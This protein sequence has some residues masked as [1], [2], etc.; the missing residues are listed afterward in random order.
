MNLIQRLATAFEI[1]LLV[2]LLGLY[3]CLPGGG[4][5]GPKPNLPVANNFLADS[6]NPVG[7][8]TPAQQD[9]VLVK[10]P[11]GP[12]PIEVLDAFNDMTYV[13]SGP[14]QFTQMSTSPYADGRRVLWGSGYDRIVKLDHD[15]QGIL[16]MYKL[17]DKTYRGFDQGERIISNLDSMSAADALNYAAS[18][19]ALLMQDL[20]GV[21]TLLDSNNEFYVSDSDNGQASITVYGDRNAGQLNSPI[22]VKRQFTLPITV[23]GSLVGVN[24]TYDGYLVLATTHGYVVVLARD[25]SDYAVIR[26]NYADTE[27]AETF[28]TP[29]YG[30]VRNSFAVDSNNAIYIASN[31]HLH[32]VQWDG[33][34]LSLTWAEPYHNATGNGSGSTPTLMGFDSEDKFVVITDGDAVMNLT[35]FWRDEIPEGWI[36]PAGAPSA[37]IAGQLPA[38]MGG[39]PAVQSEQ[40][41]VV[42]GYGAV[43]VNNLANNVPASDSI[44]VSGS[45]GNREEYQAFGVQK[46]QWDAEAK[47]LNLAWVNNEVSSV[48]GMPILGIGSGEWLGEDLLYAVGARSGAFTLEA[49]NWHNGATTFYHSLGGARF[50]S[51]YGNILLDE[52]G[53]IHYST[54]W[55]KLCL[56][57]Q[58]WP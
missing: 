54:L 10:G 22:E 29:G 46:F 32:K 42:Y 30:W 11:T 48:N 35:L 2:F 51:L 27:N 7:H 16:A 39:L 1:S 9:V 5:S 19:L 36:A 4:N 17:P 31:N 33:A 20:P 52:N 50:N 41:V 44:L 57:N 8:G 24:M 15:T 45:L 25:F 12:G 49:V 56:E 26:L 47:Q 23:T 40:S 43:V 18:D 34:A 6:N 37:R 28:A 55:G 53:R 3:G 58:N 13:A 21:Y 14:F 38:S